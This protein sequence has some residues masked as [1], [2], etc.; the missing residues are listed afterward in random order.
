MYPFIFTSDSTWAVNVCA[1]VPTG[2]T[3]VGAYDAEGNLVSQAECVH[4]AI[5]GE[6]KVIAF[7]VL[8]L[9]SPPPHLKAT[10]R[11]R[12]NGRVH[13]LSLETPGHRKGKDRGRGR[14]HRQ[15]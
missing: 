10:L 15:P 1:E 12:H 7:E 6:A 2:Y 9:E 13:A 4:T 11:I 8:D 14:G 5:A 3:I